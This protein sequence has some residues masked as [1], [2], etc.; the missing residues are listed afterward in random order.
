MKEFPSPL[1]N[2]NGESGHLCFVPDLQG[3]MFSLSPLSIM[4]AVGFFIDAPHELRKFPLYSYFS[5][6]FF[7]H[8]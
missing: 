1:S 6:N 5:K 8:E 2:K 7:Y 3:R 4:L